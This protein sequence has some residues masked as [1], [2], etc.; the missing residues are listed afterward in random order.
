MRSRRF[1]RRELL[2]GS[3]RGQTG[4]RPGSDRGLTPMVPPADFLVR[5]HRRIMACRVEVVLPGELS[6]QLAAAR[7]AL[8]EADRLEQLMTIF[9]DT[10][11]LTRVNRH[12]HEEP[13]TTDTELFSVLLQSAELNHATEGAF[14]ITSTPLSES[15]G[16]L[17]R[18][19]RIPSDEAIEAARA[20]VGMHLVELDPRSRTVRFRREGVALNLG[21]IG[22]GFALDRMGH[23]LRRNG[24][25]HALISA[26]SS[27]ILAIGGT[28]RPWEIDLRAMATGEQLA[29][30][31]VSNGAVG[32]SGAG[33]QFFEAGGVR[34]GHVIDP[35]TGHPASGV[36]SASVITSSAAS[37]DA[38]STAMLIGGADLAER[39]CA[40]HPG[41]LAIITPDHVGRDGPARVRSNDAG[42]PRPLV[43][44]SYLAASVEL[45]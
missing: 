14:D 5:V 24:V 38:L 25:D 7:A 34:Y 41:V 23:F 28:P 10:S 16:F 27:S 9:R 40:S 37:A 32:T 36:M 26:G 19:G 18:E 20:R 45:S 11:E 2:T 6:E 1:T 3:D 29:K 13:V 8:D 43:F 35:R 31:R 15:W 17:R 44:G 39:Y 4:V 42:R 30:L 22:K 12:A 33:E 21:A